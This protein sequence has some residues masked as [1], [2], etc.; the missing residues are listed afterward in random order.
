MPLIR[1]ALLNQALQLFD[2]LG[3]CVQKDQ[4]IIRTGNTAKA[5]GSYIHRTDG[6][7]V[8]YDLSW[9]VRNSIQDSACLWLRFSFR[10]IGSGYR[11]H[12]GV[13]LYRPGDN[14][15][16]KIAKLYD[17]AKAEGE[18]FR[19]KQEILSNSPLEPWKFNAPQFIKQSD[20]VRL[21]HLLTACHAMDAVS[22]RNG[23]VFRDI[24]N[25][26]SGEPFFI[27][28]CSSYTGKEFWI[29]TDG[30]IF[31]PTSK[32][33]HREWIERQNGQVWIRHSVQGVNLEFA[34]P[35]D[36]GLVTAAIQEFLDSN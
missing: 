31:H 20:G 4:E 32:I 8:L 25:P 7:R 26:N 24:E 1:K 14:T 34:S 9:D 11:A 10:S 13:A 23:E 36:K 33:N 21:Q 18:Q 17:D 2:D 19:L 28:C 35:V 16:R 12:R 5:R 15:K 27:V 3:M 6:V 30:E 29:V 22:V